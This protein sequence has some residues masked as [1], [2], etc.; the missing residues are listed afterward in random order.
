ML[1]GYGI[2]S[3]CGMLCVLMREESAPFKV[4]W[5]G[6]GLVISSNAARGSCLYT[7]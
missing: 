4:D 3:A 2:M 6:N 7:S 5:M 1:V